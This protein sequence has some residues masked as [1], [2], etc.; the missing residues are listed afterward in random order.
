MRKTVVA[1]N[2]KLNNTIAES[3]EL[4]TLLK[5]ELSDVEGVEIVVCPA[6]TALVEVGEV[7]LE[8][9]I[10]LGAQD[11][12][13]E[14]RGAFTGEVSGA[15]LR[16]AGCAYVIIGHSERRQYFHES[17]EDVHKKTKAALEAG[18]TPIVC[19]GETLDERMS[20]KTQ[21]VL[22]RQLEG[23]FKGFSSAEVLRCVIAYEPVWAI[24]TGKV[25]TPREA[26]EGHLFIRGL[27]GKAHN[28]T[29]GSE[30]VI[31]YGGSVRPENAHELLRKPDVDGFLVGGASL[32]AE[33]FVQIVRASVEVK[34]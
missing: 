1:G 23:A 10:K 5:R 27:L 8:S 31:L 11:L 30:T 7:L 13:W 2:W 24:G 14:A 22:T 6:F 4:V 18:L 21:A 20:E 3:I 28:S 17:D 25:A 19:C 9:N 32:D 29:V 34:V 26:E 16:D 12:F 15:L 33:A